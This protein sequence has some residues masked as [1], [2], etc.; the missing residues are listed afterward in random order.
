MATLT[1]AILTMAI[2]TMAILM[3]VRETTPKL[4]LCQ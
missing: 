1:M 4:N 2:L 3:N